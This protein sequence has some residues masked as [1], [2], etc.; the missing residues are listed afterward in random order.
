MDN[1]ILY[2]ILLILGIWYFNRQINKLQKMIYIANK[3][4]EQA[5]M[6]SEGDSLGIK[7]YRRLNHEII[8]GIH[9]FYLADCNMFV[10]QGTTLEDAAK[11]FTY[12][13]GNDRLGYWKHVDDK[14][15]CFIN[16]TCME[17]NNVEQN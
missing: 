4:H 11:H 1:S 16:N 7:E 6:A 12:N 13:Q 5:V 17:L 14:S 8:N 15:Y 2:T 3:L 9:Y 10:A